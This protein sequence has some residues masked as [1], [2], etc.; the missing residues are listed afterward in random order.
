MFAILNKFLKP[1]A[2][3]N[4]KTKTKSKTES[5]KPKT[6]DFFTKGIND[7]VEIVKGKDVGDQIVESTTSLNFL[8]FSLTKKNSRELG[9]LILGTKSYFSV[10]VLKSLKN[11]AQQDVPMTF[12]LDRTVQKNEEI[13]KLLA[14]FKNY[15]S[16]SI[17]YFSRAVTNIERLI[18]GFKQLNTKYVC[19]ATMLDALNVRSA[20][21]HYLKLSEQLDT[22]TILF[23]IDKATFNLVDKKAI[24]IKLLNS[25]E[26]SAFSGA[27]FNKEKFLNIVS[28]IDYPYDSW[29]PHL[30][31]SKLDTNEIIYAEEK[32]KYFRETSPND[33]S[34]PDISYFVRDTLQIIKS[35]K[36][37]NKSAD[38]ILKF[39]DS[40][41]CAID[42]QYNHR[43]KTELKT[44]I[45]ASGSA[46]IASKLK[47]FFDVEIFEEILYKFSS[48]FNFDQDLKAQKLQLTHHQ[49]INQIIEVE[50]NTIGVIETKFMQDLEGSI[51]ERLRS[52]YNVIYLTKPQYYDFHFFNCLVL[53]T[54]LQPAEYVISSNDMHRYITG[55]KKVVI[56]WHGLGMLKKIAE[57]DR[58]KYPL[59]FIV[60]S[61]EACVEPW[62]E[63]FKV[64]KSNVLPLGQVQTDILFDQTYIK[65]TREKILNKYNIPLD[66]NVI[67]F[68]PTFRND[69]KTKEKYYNFG[70]DIDELSKELAEK[71]YYI[72]SKK[73]HVFEHILKD[74]GIDKSGLSNSKNGHFVIADTESFPELIA[75]SNM[76][77]TDY[78][79]GL[80]YALAIDMP[81]ALYAPDVEEY[82][83]G[84]NGFM[85]SYPSDLPFEFCGKPNI[86]KFISII[87]KSLN[88]EISEDYMKFKEIHVGSCDGNA[89]EKVIDF[90]HT[91]NGESFPVLEVIEEKQEEDITVNEEEFPNN[92]NNVEQNNNDSDK[93]VL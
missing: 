72:I 65:E 77:I 70:I 23:N 10:S 26:I 84:A 15:P 40:I 20:Y 11:Y 58:V 32:I 49:I 76:F 56:L 74:K 17:S 5:L 45:L 22:K 2:K 12:L 81:I 82:S 35:Y 90:L 27:L 71:N 51:L 52:E 39:V 25:F 29:V 78:S 87:D 93:G 44:I 47:E 53:R 21:D 33:I 50:K 92:V 30:I 19:I 89:K 37:H 46:I 67:F 68:A 24:Y 85:I 80:F 79:S 7:F 3:T 16:V 48:V 54:L 88:S 75:T 8:K 62:S 4:A 28:E 60:T 57:A 86:T 13:T 43:N 63:T 83:E 41:V 69:I 91:W 14:E 36:R 1:K 59:D 38:E 18:T 66:A 42:N 55:G 61:S 64:P 34:V 6:P 9:F 73:H 31:L